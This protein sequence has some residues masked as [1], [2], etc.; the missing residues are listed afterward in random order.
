MSWVT[1]GSKRPREPVCSP[2]FFLPLGNRSRKPQRHERAENWTLKNTWTID[3][4]QTCEEKL[5][6][7]SQIQSA[8]ISSSTSS[9]EV[10]EGGR[11]VTQQTHGHTCFLT[12]PLVIILLWDRGFALSFQCFLGKQIPPYECFCPAST[13]NQGWM[14]GTYSR[15]GTQHLKK[16]FISC[17]HIWSHRNFFLGSSYPNLQG[18]SPLIINSPEV[19]SFWCR[20]HQRTAEL[21][22]IPCHTGTGQCGRNVK[23]PKPGSC[24]LAQ[25]HPGTSGPLHIRED[26]WEMSTSRHVS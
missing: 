11:K 19:V 7:S 18:A 17:Y 3:D 20:S 12:T 25:P 14:C 9:Q 16:Y 23:I 5:I 1:S 4:H 21:G 2:T 8:I 22:M 6:Y 26:L 15:A 13:L 24:R 10:I